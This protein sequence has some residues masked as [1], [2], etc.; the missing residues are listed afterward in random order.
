MSKI[1]NKKEKKKG[2]LF[3][4]YNSIFNDYFMLNI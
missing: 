2:G 4:Q 3:L 1:N